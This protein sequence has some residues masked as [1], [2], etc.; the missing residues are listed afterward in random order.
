M[1]WRPFRR[2]CMDNS[3]I[4]FTVRDSIAHCILN[5]PPKNEMDT[6]FFKALNRLR[7]ETFP[8]LRVKGMLV[9]GKG[10]HFSSGANIRELTSLCRNTSTANPVPLLKENIDTFC[11]LESLPFPV[12]AVINGCCL[13]AGLELALACHYR[14]ASHRAVFSLPESTYGLMPGCGGTIRLPRLIKKGN[15]IRLII[16][17]EVISAE[18]AYRAG[19]IDV[20][21]EKNNCTAEAQKLVNRKTSSR[22]IGAAVDKKTGCGND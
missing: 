19:L 11:F 6:S 21:T 4:L 17:G 1:A 2:I 8:T 22:E 13:G 16:S 20:V 10:R 14:V 15:A 7:K 12:V 9:Y 5:N 18:D 3:P